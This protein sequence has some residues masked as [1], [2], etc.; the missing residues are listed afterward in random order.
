MQQYTWDAVAFTVGYS[1]TYTKRLGA[2]A[3]Y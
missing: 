1:S 2:C 3:P